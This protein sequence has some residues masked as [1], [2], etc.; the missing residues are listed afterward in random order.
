M[1]RGIVECMTNESTTLDPST[2]KIKDELPDG[3]IITVGAERFF[4]RGS[5]VT[6]KFDW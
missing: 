5:V 2:M 6:A 3:N 1:S 4:L